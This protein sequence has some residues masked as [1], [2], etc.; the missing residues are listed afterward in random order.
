M[1]KKLILIIFFN[2][3]VIGCGFSPIYLAKDYNDFQITKIKFKGNAIIN[4]FIG[5][6]LKKYSSTIFDQSLIETKKKTNF[7]ILVNT[8]FKK[9][10][11]TKDKSGNATDYE[12]IIKS[13]FTILDEKFSKKMIIINEKFLVENKD[14]KYEENNYERIV[15]Q[16]LSNIISEKL[17]NQ[18]SKIK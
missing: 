13:N 14:N 4:N 5:L 3:L 12:L 16:N 1:I 2:S 8:S 11:L 15:Q 18:L 7:E 17:I 9:V 6:N 10:I